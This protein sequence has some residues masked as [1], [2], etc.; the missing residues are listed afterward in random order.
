M[1][2]VLRTAPGSKNQERTGSWRGTYLSL[3]GA[4]GGVPES[5]RG[6]VTPL[7]SWPRT[8]A[9]SFSTWGPADA[10]ATSAVAGVDDAPR[11]LLAPFRVELLSV[12]CAAA[13]PAFNSLIFLM[14]WRV[15]LF[16]AADGGGPEAPVISTSGSLPMEESEVNSASSSAG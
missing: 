12:C 1:T 4:A 3:S 10:D 9:A 16:R 15:F 14:A 8:W 2:R 6:G 7:R 11:T 13:N 5:A